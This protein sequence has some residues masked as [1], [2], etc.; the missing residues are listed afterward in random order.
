MVVVDRTVVVNAELVVDILVVA[1]PGGGGPGIV[2][3][4]VVGT[5]VGVVVPDEE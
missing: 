3:G 2:V 1:G 5:V 4:V